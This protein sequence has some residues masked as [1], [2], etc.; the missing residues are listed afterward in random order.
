MIKYFG[1][2]NIIMRY[3]T[4]I[5]TV[6]EV[7]LKCTLI[8]IRFITLLRTN[9]LLNIMKYSIYDGEELTTEE[10][11]LMDH[12]KKRALL[13]EERKKQNLKKSFMAPISAQV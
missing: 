5:P 3:N 8:C 2:G 4:K 6:K 12:Y 9:K 1:G 7:I 11:A 10:I 13:F